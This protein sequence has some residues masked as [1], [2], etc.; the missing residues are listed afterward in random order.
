MDMDE[1]EWHHRHA[2]PWPEPKAAHAMDLLDRLFS[3]A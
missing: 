1:D 3:I 2:G